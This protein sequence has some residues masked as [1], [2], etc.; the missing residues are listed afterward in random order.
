M[1]RSTAHSTGHAVINLTECTLDM[2][3]SGLKTGNIYLD[4]SKAF[5]CIDHRILLRKLEHYGFRGATL[6]WFE[7]YL[8]DREQYVQVRENSSNRYKSKLGIIQGGVLAP[9]L[10][11]LYT[12]DLINSSKQFKF[13]ITYIWVHITKGSLYTVS[14]I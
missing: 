2:L 14:M 3:D 4:V 1:E 7:S 9:I 5:D 10:F 6:M 11:I 12:N 8:S 13:S